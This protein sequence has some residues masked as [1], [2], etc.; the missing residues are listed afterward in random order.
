MGVQLFL[1]PFVAFYA[2]SLTTDFNPM[3]RL[4]GVCPCLKAWLHQVFWNSFLVDAVPRKTSS[5]HHGLCLPY[6]PVS[7]AKQVIL[8]P[9]F[10]CLNSEL[11]SNTNHPQCSP[12][13]RVSKHTLV[14]TLK[15]E[16][17][18]LSQRILTGDQLQL[19]DDLCGPSMDLLQ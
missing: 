14:S 12:G 2:V 10:L 8:S 13:S 9:Y 3:T 6:L 15:A 7:A 1:C 4:D 16:Q 19:S 11:L 5:A 18:Q 17:P